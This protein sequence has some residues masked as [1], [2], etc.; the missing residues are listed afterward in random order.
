MKTNFTTEPRLIGSFMKMIFKLML[1]ILFMTIGSFK[2]SAQEVNPLN[3][4]NGFNLFTEGNANLGSNGSE[5]E[6][7]AAIGGDLTITG[8]YNIYMNN[9]NGFPIP[10]SISGDPIALAV[11]GKVNFNFSQSGERFRVLNGA[12]AKINNAIGLRE[13]SLD[14]NHAQINLRLVKSNDAWDA[15]GIEFVKK[16]TDFNSDVFASTGIDFNNAFLDLRSVSLQLAGKTDDFA[17]LKVNGANITNASNLSNN[18]NLEVQL[19][20]GVNY[21]NI[22]SSQLNKINEINLTG[23]SLGDGTNNT[24]FLIINV[25]GNGSFE[26]HPGNLSPGGDA[27]AS[28]LLYNFPNITELK[29]TQQGQEVRGSILAPTADI[30]KTI[31]HNHNIVGQ[32]IGKTF[33]GQLGSGEVHYRPFLGK[34]NLEENEP[35]ICNIPNSF[36]YVTIADG[37]WGDASIWETGTGGFVSSAPNPNSNT[38]LKILITHRVE[39]FK[40]G[41]NNMGSM[42]LTPKKNTTIVVKDGGNMIVEGDL[43]ISTNDTRLI[44]H[45][46]SVRTLTGDITFGNVDAAFCAID[47]CIAAGEDIEL[48]SGSHY[49]ENSGLVAYGYLTSNRG[50]IDVNSSVTIEGSDIRLWSNFEFRVSNSGVNWDPQSITGWYAESGLGSSNHFDENDLPA[51]HPSIWNACLDE[52]LP[53]VCE[54]PTSYDYETISD[55]LWDDSSTWKNGLIP[56]NGA[57]KIKNKNILITHVIERVNSNIDTEDVTFFIDGGSLTLNRK[58]TLQGDSQMIIENGHLETINYEIQFKDNTTFCAINSCVIAE[59]AF[60]HNSG[61]AHIESTGITS[62]TNDIKFPRQPTITGSDMRFWAGGKINVSNKNIDWDFENTVSKWYS[63]AK[64]YWDGSGAPSNNQLPPMEDASYDP[65]ED[66]ITE[67]CLS[68][69]DQVELIK[70]VLSNSD[71]PSVEESLFFEDFGTSDL[72]N[73][74]KGRVESPFMPNNGFDFGNSYLQLPTPTGNPWDDNP[75]RNAARINDGFYAVVAPGYII[76]GW[77]DDDGWDSWWTP[78]YNEANPIYDYSGTET[79]AALVI[80][81]GENLTTFYERNGLIQVGA[82]YRASFKLFVVQAPSQVGIDIIDP[83]TRDVIY[84]MQTDKYQI[85]Y[86]NDEYTNWRSIAVEFTLPGSSCNAKEVI[87]SFRNHFALVD[88]N[89]WYVDNIRLEK[90]QDAPTCPPTEQCVTNGKTSVNLNDAF[91]GTIPTGTT[92]VWYTTPDRSGEP[93]ANPENIKE[94]GLYYAFFYDAENNCYNVEQSTAVVEVIII[95]PCTTVIAIPDFN[96]TPQE[97]PVDGNVLI[98]DNGDNIVVVEISVRDAYGTLKNVSIPN[99]G[100]MT[101]DVYVE[102]PNSSGNYIKAGTITIDSNGQYTFTPKE[103]FIGNATMEYTIEDE[104]GQTDST[105]LNIEVIPI[106]I[107]VENNDPIAQDDAYTTIEGK[108]ITSNVLNN[109]SDPDGD[110]LS[111]TTIT[112]GVNPI[113]MS[114]PTTVSGVDLQ[115]NP[116]SDAGTVTIDS[117]GKITFVPNSGFIGKINPINYIAEDGKGGRDDAY[118]YINVLPN[119]DINTTFAFDDA[120]VA[121]KGITMTGNVLENDFDPEGD[122]QVLTSVTIGGTEYSITPGSPE[123]ISIPGKGSLTIDSDGDY[124]FVPEPEFVGT[125]VIEQKVCDDGVPQACDKATLYLTSL[126]VKKPTLLITNPMIRQKTKN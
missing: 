78:G 16:K 24:G 81:A 58:L 2:L 79:G 65:C 83:V 53:R 91:E 29:F 12:F 102:N 92:L 85:D 104:K 125:V 94:S 64:T 11:N 122:D 33:D 66:I 10:Y 48:K 88:G 7:P 103:G 109:D 44:V 74:N 95:P 20:S 56:D 5:M 107:P 96:Q 3:A 22:P 21:L 123:V 89:D 75:V 117:N 116:V 19:H 68:G 13:V 93:V 54:T 113:S 57:T 110:T 69:I 27:N 28:Y 124:I 52:I 126:D 49:V 62:L 99:I 82:K 60:E 77:F 84:T 50:R 25:T 121:P 63:A 14:N 17:G 118:I 111:V 8:S 34:I 112:Q 23:V 98:N 73:G 114:T 90:I 87:V 115:G 32:I 71:L 106:Y 1:I 80:N 55:G 86:N 38:D 40:N 6:G 105:T 46:A 39:F 36:D 76:E 108:T 100:T 41:N 67:I 97:T 30:K 45:D 61:N 43:K 101:E 47:A 35:S 119:E 72:N 120:N 42:N 18:T 31:Q 4:A 9:L 26:W 15:Q 70:T 59:K 51:M 37:D